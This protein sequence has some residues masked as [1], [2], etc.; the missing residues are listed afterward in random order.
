MIDPPEHSSMRQLGSNV[1]I[2]NAPASQG[3]NGQGFLRSA[4]SIT[5]GAGFR[6]PDG[7]VPTSP[8]DGDTW[9]TNAG[10]FT[11]INGITKTVTLT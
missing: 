7:T 1:A 2:S 10:M 11:R 9:T 4:A 5:A 3:L 8:V 6:V